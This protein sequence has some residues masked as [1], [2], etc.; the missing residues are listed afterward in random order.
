MVFEGKNVDKLISAQMDGEE[1]KLLSDGK[2]MIINYNHKHKSEM[3]L[4]I[5][6]SIS[7]SSVK[8][9]FPLW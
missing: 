8:T 3:V 4:S 2:R 9:L 7:V 5:K 1:I 6:F